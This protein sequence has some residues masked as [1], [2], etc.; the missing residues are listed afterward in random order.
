MGQSKKKKTKKN[1][2]N[3]KKP[4]LFLTRLITMASRSACM[5]SILKLSILKVYLKPFRNI[6]TI[7]FLDKIFQT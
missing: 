3:K 4:T 6:T 7:D 2:T 1:K 5:V